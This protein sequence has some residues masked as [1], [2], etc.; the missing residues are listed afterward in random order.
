MQRVRNGISA[1]RQLRSS[2]S[3]RAYDLMDKAVK[4]SKSGAVDIGMNVGHNIVTPIVRY[5]VVSAL[6]GTDPELPNS[7]RRGVDLLA[8]DICVSVEI[9]IL[10]ALRQSIGGSAETAKFSPQESHNCC[11]PNCCT[12]LRSKIL[13]ILYPYDRSIWSQLRDPWY[14]ILKI[15]TIFPMF[16]VSMSTWFILWLLKDKRD[17]YSL[18]RFI[19]D[20]KCSLFISSVINSILG[21]VMYL[22][23]TTINP[24]GLPCHSNSPGQMQ[25]FWP[26]AAFFVL[27]LALTFISALLNCCSKVKGKHASKKSD[28]LG[29]TTIVQQLERET[30]RRRSRIFCWL[31]YD[32]VAVTIVAALVVFAVVSESSYGSSGGNSTYISST[33]PIYTPE[34]HIP[35]DLAEVLYWCR[36]LY[37]WLCFP[38][39]LLLLPGM[40][41]LLTH[42]KPTGYSRI[43]KTLPIASAMVRLK[44][45]QYRQ[46]LRKNGGNLHITSENNSGSNNS[47]SNNTS[48]NNNNKG[49]TN[50]DVEI[51]GVNPMGTA[52]KSNYESSSRNSSGGGRN[53]SSNNPFGRG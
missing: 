33:N 21:N 1:A 44:N 47:G 15:F 25:P 29:K 16:Y 2:A 32:I 14:Y 35:R 3:T 51:G 13:Y 6:G 20:L 4:G 7:V 24:K 52:E 17:E 18:V 42:T 23:C 38:W 36:V 40:F 30:R 48:G 34:Q 43:G 5:H 19:V 45:Y 9:K 31:V 26:V 50:R 11:R 22:R 10:E 41:P 53:K 12:Y 27:Q 28:D 39:M 37:G 8:E 49:T 46:E